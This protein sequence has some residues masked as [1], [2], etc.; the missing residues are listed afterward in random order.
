MNTTT[1]TTTAASIPGTILAILCIMMVWHWLE[2]GEGIGTGI[3]MTVHDVKVTF[4]CR[5]FDTAF[6]FYF[7]RHEDYLLDRQ[8]FK[9]PNWRHFVC[10]VYAHE[11]LRTEADRLKILKA[12]W[13]RI[14]P[15]H[16]VRIS[17][18]AHQY[19]EPYVSLWG[20]SIPEPP[21]Q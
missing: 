18:W 16:Q 10:P 14:P 19:G 17:T 6:R 4:S 15:V 9:Y 11:S 12:A 20:Y 13:E 7:R 1:V 21:T 3:K 5:S 2:S 8:A